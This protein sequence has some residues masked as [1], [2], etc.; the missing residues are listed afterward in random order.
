MQNN[1]EDFFFGYDYQI[2]VEDYLVVLVVVFKFM[3]DLYFLG[4]R[5]FK[6]V[7]DYFKLVVVVIEIVVKIIF[8]LGF[9]V[10]FGWD[11]YNYEC[12][13]MEFSFR[14]FGMCICLVY[15]FVYFVLLVF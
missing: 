15:F 10:V 3:M 14:L 13:L 12:Y 1:F 7:V 5:K 4:R 11:F 6:Y 2:L 8:I 9:V